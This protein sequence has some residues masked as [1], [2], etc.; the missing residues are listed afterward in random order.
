MKAVRKVLGD[1]EVKCEIRIKKIEDEFTT[2][3]G[4]LTL[5]DP[6]QNFCCLEIS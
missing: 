6:C 1:D 3:S 5:M 2:N 4:Y